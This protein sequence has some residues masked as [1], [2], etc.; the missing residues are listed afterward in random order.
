MKPWADWDGEKR[1]RFE[2]LVRLFIFGGLSREK[3]EEFAYEKL[4]E[5]NYG[6]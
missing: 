4:K 5:D 2:G 1:E 6:A 3:A